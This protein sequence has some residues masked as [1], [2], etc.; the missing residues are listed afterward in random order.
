ML[1]VYVTTVSFDDEE[2]ILCYVILCRNLDKFDFIYR[3][4]VGIKST[5]DSICIIFNKF[6]RKLTCISY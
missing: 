6:T 1:F 2:L 3:F 5:M 4:K